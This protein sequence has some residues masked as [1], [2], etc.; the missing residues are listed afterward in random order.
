MYISNG[1]LVQTNHIICW[2]WCKMKTQQILVQKWLRISRWWL[3]SIKPSWEPS[4]VAPCVACSQALPQEDLPC[5]HQPPVAGAH[6]RTH[7]RC[8]VQEVWLDYRASELAD[9]DGNQDCWVPEIWR[10]LCL[11]LIFLGY[12]VVTISS[13]F[14]TPKGW[15]GSWQENKCSSQGH[16]KQ[17]VIVWALA[18]QPQK[19]VLWGAWLCVAPTE[20]Q[21][22][23]SRGADC[24]P[25]LGCFVQL[26]VGWH[27][28]CLTSGTCRGSSHYPCECLEEKEKSRR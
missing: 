1:V 26:E 5:P 17:R 13:V 4:G 18:A 15:Q 8:E 3:Q 9:R 25:T 19:Q 11:L 27:S 7:G 6:S 14:L 28:P 23:A 12:Q 16:K 10:F 21:C 24:S 22:L 20:I 2:V